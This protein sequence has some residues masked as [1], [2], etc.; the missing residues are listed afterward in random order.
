MTAHGGKREGAGR[1]PGA[2][3]KARKVEIVSLADKAKVHADAAIA[4]L[5]EICKTG[6]TESA[7]VA[8]ANAIL[9]RA[10]GKPKQAVDVSSETPMPF[11]AFVLMEAT[12]NEDSAVSIN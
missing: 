9:D 3:T 2:R 12:G 6:S 11:G 5:A 4:T 7:R 1:K 8:A 10:Y